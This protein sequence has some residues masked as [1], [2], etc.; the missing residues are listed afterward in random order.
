MVGIDDYPSSPLAGCVK[1]AS[2]MAQ[3]LG[4]HHD[5]APN[6]DCKTL[7]SPGAAVTRS[8]LRTA[9][10]ELFDKQVQTALF[11]FAGHGAKTTRGGILVTQDAKANDE[12]VTFTELLEM[13]AQSK[14]SEKVVVLDCCFGG[15]VATLPLFEDSKVIPKESC[16]L[17][18]CRD[19]E[20][21]Q[22]TAKGGLFT[23][24][25]V[26]ALEG[27]GADATGKVTIAN[28]YTHVDDILSGWQ[29]R[30]MFGANVSNMIPLR[31]CAPAVPLDVL[32]LLTKYFPEPEHEFPLDPAYEPDGAAPDPDKV[33]IFGH[34]QRLR[35]ARML[36]PLGATH[37]YYAAVN[38]QACQLTALGRYY[39]HRAK[40]G[41]I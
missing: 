26:S 18:G 3:I 14:A 27:A 12:G 24:L 17:A 22:E 30:P 36:L 37:L 39:W 32:R 5:G 7:L 33:R 41:R 34:L 20:T 15:A 4:T 10:A 40:S 21:A 8:A 6:F 29:Q 31:N 13:V 1:D 11:Y 25:V 35:D 38:S 23:S 19:T 28:V 16:F 9:V 2:R